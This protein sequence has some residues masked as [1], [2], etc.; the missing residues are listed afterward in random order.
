LAGQEPVAFDSFNQ[1]ER[2]GFTPTVDFYNDRANAAL[3]GGHTSAKEIKQVEADLKQ[4]FEAD[5]GNV[6]AR[7]TRLLLALQQ[8]MSAKSSPTVD[9]V[10][11]EEAVSDMNLLLQKYGQYAEVQELAV[12]VF[13]A[14]GAG[15]A[16]GEAQQGLDHCRQAVNFGCDKKKL[17]RLPPQIMDR[18]GRQAVADALRGL[19]TPKGAANVLLPR[20]ELLRDP[21]VHWLDEK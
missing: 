18:L 16:S 4:V 15:P 11:P 3:R 9:D 6:P 10:L 8:W 14:R 21:G 12:S 19:E 1:A 5:P 13:A 2:A 7:W 20:A 17:L